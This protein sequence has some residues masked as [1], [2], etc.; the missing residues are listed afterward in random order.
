MKKITFLLTA[1]LSLNVFGQIPTSGLVAYFPFTGNANDS[2]GNATNGTTYNV[3]LTTDR[4]GNSNSAY[5]FSG[6]TNSYISFPSTNV[7]N[8]T[9]SYS[10]WLNVKNMPANGSSVSMVEI[11]QGGGGTGQQMTLHNNYLNVHTGLSVGGYNQTS[12][13]FGLTTKSL[14]S[15][16]T[17]YHLASVRNTNYI[18]LY[19]NGN[20][21]DSQ[22][23][24]NTILPK[25]GSPV[26]AFIGVRCDN[27]NPFNGAIDEVCIYNRPITASE[28]KQL[29]LN[30]TASTEIVSIASNIKIYP[31]PAIGRLTIDLSESNCS[32][33]TFELI[34][35]NG[36]L[37]KTEK[38]DGGGVH[39]INISDIQQGLYFVKL[40]NP[41]GMTIQR[42]QIVIGNK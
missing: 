26:K 11:G 37:V 4:F 15:T 17:W 19:V 16:N 12:P 31:N 13:N 38:F 5:L 27:T 2:S 39:D 7:V 24:A 28:V 30:G 9:Y 20:L 10:I 42:E 3:S 32:K 25:Y 23:V 36:R 29:Y 34:D 22:G 35:L 1:L 6:N 8:S 14:P 21:I 18:L 41:Q 40:I 33:G